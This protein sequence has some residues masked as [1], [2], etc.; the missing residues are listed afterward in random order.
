MHVLIVIVVRILEVI[1]GLG[2]F[3]SCI[4]VILGVIDDIKTFIKY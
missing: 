4:S 3:V 1:F 2:L